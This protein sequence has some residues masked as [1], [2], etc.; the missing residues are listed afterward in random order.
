MV[1]FFLFPWCSTPSP[2][3]S[4]LPFRSPSRPHPLPS[5][6]NHHYP[7]PFCLQVAPLLNLP[8]SSPSPLAHLLLFSL[9]TSPHSSNLSLLLLTLPPL[10]IPLFSPRDCNHSLFFVFDGVLPPSLLG[11]IS[12]TFFFLPPPPQKQM[13]LPTREFSVQ[14][15]SSFPPPFYKE[16]SPPTSPISAVSFFLFLSTALSSCTFS[17]LRFLLRFFSPRGDEEF[18]TFFP[19]GEVDPFPLLLL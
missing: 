13:S 17:F 1:I 2:T 10:L 19:C 18:L 6:S 9:S 14:K 12:E 7:P 3:P 5:S 4:P 15:G 11:D 16:G 8:L